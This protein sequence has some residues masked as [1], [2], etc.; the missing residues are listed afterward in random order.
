MQSPNR[1]EGC[2][3]LETCRPAAEKWSA[4]D[5]AINTKGNRCRGALSYCCNPGS[6][7]ARSQVVEASTGRDHPPARSKLAEPTAAQ[8]GSSS[9]TA[10]APSERRWPGRAGGLDLVLDHYLLRRVGLGVVSPSR[11]RRIRSTSSAPSQRETTTVATPLAEA[12]GAPRYR[13]GPVP[14]SSPAFLSP[15]LLGLAFDRWR[16]GISASS[17]GISRDKRPLPSLSVSSIAR[18]LRRNR[19]SQLSKV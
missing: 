6:C 12:V 9:D 3:S 15:I 18:H 19:R 4:H 1:S 7:S 11:C 13:H 17:L 2:A 14:R 5:C 8:K 10:M 16:R